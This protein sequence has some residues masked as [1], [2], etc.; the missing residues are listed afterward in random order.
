[1]SY[2]FTH[3]GIYVFILFYKALISGVFM[4]YRKCIFSKYALVNNEAEEVE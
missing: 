2:S 1:M 4:L 3:L